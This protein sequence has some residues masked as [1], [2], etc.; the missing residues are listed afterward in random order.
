MP[1]LRNQLANCDKNKL[2]DE[3]NR[4]LHEK[5]YKESSGFQVLK[6]NQ[7]ICTIH[8]SNENVPDYN[9]LFHDNVHLNYS[10]GV[11]MLEIFFVIF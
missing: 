6:L 4:F 1:P 10:S 9:Q 11:P 7:I 2:I 3:F 5:L 8:N